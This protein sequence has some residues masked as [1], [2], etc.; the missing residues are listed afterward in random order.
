[1]SIQESFKRFKC[2][3][4]FCNTLDHLDVSSSRS[5]ELIK[6]PKEHT[7]SS[8]E[9]RPQGISEILGSIGGSQ[10]DT[11]KLSFV[12]FCISDKSVLQCWCSFFLLEAL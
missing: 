4:K 1:M 10:R 11:V 5:S 6:S 12:Q 8:F 2:S 3:G 7:L 9:V